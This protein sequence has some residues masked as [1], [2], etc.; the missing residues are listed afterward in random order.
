MRPVKSSRRYSSRIRQAQAAATRRQIVDA[1]LNAFLEDGYAGATMQRIAAAAGVV[2]ETIY[3]TFDGK[4]ALFKAAV[5]AAVAGGTER[6]ER[7]V[8]QRPAIRAVIAEPDP[9]RKLERYAAT[10]PGIH[11]RLA[12]LIRRLLRQRRSGRSS[13]RYGT[14]LS[15]SALRAWADSRSTSGRRARFAPR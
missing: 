12:P 7:P 6:A 13:D 3:R 10:Q 9:R 11:K 15:C 14:K 5:E 2:V 4:A 1:A 8:E